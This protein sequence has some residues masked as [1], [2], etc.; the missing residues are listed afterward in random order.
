M[1]EIAV[2][3]YGLCAGLV[4]MIATRNRREARPN[5]AVVTAMGWGLMS[6]SSVLALLLATVALAMALGAQGPLLEAL[7][8]A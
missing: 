2:F 3:L 4:L 6:M 5:P 7:A 8:A 1:L